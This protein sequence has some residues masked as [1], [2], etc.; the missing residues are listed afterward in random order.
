MEVCYTFSVWKEEGRKGVEMEGESWKDIRSDRQ[1]GLS[2]T[3]IA[4]RYNGK[5]V[6]RE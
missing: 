6:R 2:Y 3:E 5:E 1:K 4:R